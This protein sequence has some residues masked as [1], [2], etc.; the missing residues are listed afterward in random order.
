M[1]RAPQALWVAGTQCL[2]GHGE[3][4]GGE[5]AAGPDGEGP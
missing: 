2:R 4:D 5:M 1:L 3:N